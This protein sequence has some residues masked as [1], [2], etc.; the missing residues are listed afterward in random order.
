VSVFGARRLA[1]A[2]RRGFPRSLDGAP[3]LL[4]RQHSALRLALDDWFDREGVRPHVVGE[5]DDSALMKAL[6]QAGLGLFPAPSP[7]AAEVCRQYN[8]RSIGTI[9]SIRQRF[10]A[11]TV[12]RNVKHPAVIAICEAARHG[13][14]Q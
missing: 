1:G 3:F 9:E 10:Y 5:F 4:P 2:Y 12:D 7:I 11:I 6:G 8:V 13:L 14:F